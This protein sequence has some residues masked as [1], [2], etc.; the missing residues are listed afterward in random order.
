MMRRLIALFIL[1][2]A[3]LSARSPLFNLFGSYFPGWMVCVLAA[4]S[5]SVCV[6]LVVRKLNW[7]DYLE[8][9]VVTYS[10]LTLFF[11]FTLW[12]LMFA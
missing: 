11:S 6:R 1:I 4:I 9:A 3:P 12:L 8:P 7:D 2:A 5:L 10:A